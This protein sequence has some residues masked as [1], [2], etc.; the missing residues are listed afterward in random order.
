MVS[1]SRRGHLRALWIEDG[2]IPTPQEAIERLDHLRT[3]GDTP[4]AFTLKQILLLLT[5]M[6]IGMESAK[7][8]LKA[9]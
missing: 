3:N 8:N 9:S 6:Q 5:Y 1:S 2:H 7:K 4:F